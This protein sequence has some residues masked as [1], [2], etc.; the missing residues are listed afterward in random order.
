MEDTT[1]LLGMNYSHF[2]QKPAKKQAKTEEH[3]VESA[4]AIDRWRMWEV[5]QRKMWEASLAEE[6]KHSGW[7]FAVQTRR[8]N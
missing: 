8:Q 5:W 1:P 6:A 2:D 3:N 7:I 4:K